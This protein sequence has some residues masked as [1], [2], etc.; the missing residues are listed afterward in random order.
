LSISQPDFLGDGVVTLRPW[1]DDYAGALVERINDP[2]VAEFMDIIPQPYSLADAH[3]F[4]ARSLEG[5]RTGASTNFAIFVDGIVGA[6]GGIGLHWDQR[7]QGVEEWATGSAPTRAGAAS[8]RRP[9]DS[10]R[11][12][13]S[14]RLL[15]SNASSSAPTN[16]T[17]RRTASPRRPGS[18]VRAFCARA[19]STRASTVASTS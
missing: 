6:T 4:L 3:E 17:S 11:A 2:A 5:W 16:R 10:L 15:T 7:E 9:R 18:R 8:L 1:R 12:G 19:G 14:R 13:H